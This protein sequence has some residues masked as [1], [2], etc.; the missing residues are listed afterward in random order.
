MDVIPTFDAWLTA[1]SS[2]DSNEARWFSDPTEVLH[3]LKPTQVVEYLQRLF[4]EAH[5]HCAGISSAR[6][7]QMIWFC[8]GVNSSYWHEV[9]SKDVPKEDQ[10]LTVRALGSFYQKFLDPYFQV[11][12][13]D[14]A[15]A[16]DA[17]YMMCDMDC[18]EGAAMFPGAEHLV[19]PIFEVLGIALRCRSE[20]CQQSALHGLGH[21]HAYH[22]RRVEAEIDWAL[23]KGSALHRSLITY[24]HEART[25]N[26]Q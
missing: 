24:A 21:L 26:I 7:A 25:G 15:E 16:A 14:S 2:F 12:S 10:V 3:S 4:N 13:R 9:R 23:G 11:A 8:N 6:L 18:L 1:I 5:L 19:D 17:V 22:P 20:P